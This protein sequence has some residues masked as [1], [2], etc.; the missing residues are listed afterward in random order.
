MLLPSLTLQQQRTQFTG[1]EDGA[2]YADQ[3]VYTGRCPRQA[4][5]FRRV[6]A[7]RPRAAAV[8]VATTSPGLPPPRRADCRCSA[9][10]TPRRSAERECETC[11]RD[12]CRYCRQ[13]PAAGPRRKRLLKRLDN[14]LRR[15]DIVGTVKHDQR[16]P[17][18]HFQTR[19]PSLR[20]NLSLPRRRANASPVRV[21]LRCRRR[22][23]R[24]WRPDARPADSV[25]TAASA[26]ATLSPER[27][28]A[29]KLARIFFPAH[30][31][32]ENRRPTA[33][34]AP[35]ERGR[36]VRSPAGLLDRR[37]R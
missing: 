31:E 4:P 5:R 32:N 28:Q 15:G 22:R 13:I 24:R 9:S 14:R 1:Q 18:H 10:D 29:G 19:R 30:N 34:T 26:A 35:G 20:A 6:A 7:Q 11:P 33:V 21:T 16:L 3:I 27:V 37:R 25:Q 23:R 2:G 36:F 12:P 17:L 8:R